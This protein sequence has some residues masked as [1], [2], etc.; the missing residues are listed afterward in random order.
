M[1]SEIRRNKA[2]G[3][4]VIYA[5]NRGQRPDQFADDTAEKPLP[6]HDPECPF[7]S[8]NE[9]QIPEIIMSLPAQDN[10]WQTRVIANKFPALTLDA[11]TKRISNNI[12]LKMPTYGRHEVIIE[13]PKHNF[14]IPDMNDNE[15]ENI[16]ETYHQ[17]Y[18][19]LLREHHDMR[20]IIFRNHGERAGTSIQHPHSQV[21]MTP[22]VSRE[23]QWC[24]REAL[25]YY[26]EH[27]ANVYMD[28]L[29]TELDNG[30]RIIKENSAFVAF[31]PFAAQVPYETWIVPRWQ[32]SDFGMINDDEK[33]HLARI[34]HRVLRNLN[35]K[36]ENPSYNLIIQTAAHYAAQS[37]Y[38]QWYVQIRPRTTTPAGFEIGSGMLINPSLPEDNAEHLIS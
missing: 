30:N 38:Q 22:I 27:G 19:D 16:I 1:S 25:R 35:N 21:V 31:I 36:L 9:G 5:P 12:H 6:E 33:A 24:E 20:V 28:M 15:I 10:K 37:P 4:W 2:T 18:L 11:S 8:G 17:R 29:Q 32:Q 3:Q 7:C 13:H 34:L 14:D 23:M 26:N